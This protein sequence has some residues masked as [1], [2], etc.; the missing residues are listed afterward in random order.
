MNEKA[1]KVIVDNS[2]RVWTRNTD[3][4]TK[5]YYETPDDNYEHTAESIR[6]NFG[7]RETR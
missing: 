6:S 1:P 2:G 5:V 4:A 3:P 7:I